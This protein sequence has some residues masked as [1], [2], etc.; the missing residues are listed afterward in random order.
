M[1]TSIQIW[2]YIERLESAKQKR[3]LQWQLQAREPIRSFA[4]IK[5]GDHL[6]RKNSVIN[7]L[8]PYEHH[9]LCIGNKFND[10]GVYKPE[11]I[12]YYNTPRNA[13]M[14]TSSTYSF[15]SGVSIGKIAKI[16]RMFLPHDDFIE[17]EDELQAAGLEVE[18]VVWP[19]ELRRYDVDEVVARAETRIAE[20]WYDAAENNCE[21]FVMWCLCNLNITLQMT[22]NQ[23][24]LYEALAAAKNMAIHGATQWVPYI[25][26]I[27]ATFA[28]VLEKIP[29]SYVDDII[30]ALKSVPAIG[31]F[32]WQTLHTNPEAL[33]VTI[34]FIIELI[35]AVYDIRIAYKKWNREDPITTRNEFIKEVIDTIVTAP[36]RFAGSAIGIMC[37]PVV[38]PIPYLIGIFAW[39]LIG[40]FFGDFTAKILTQF[41]FTQS[42]AD[43]TEWIISKFCE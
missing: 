4:D 24:M 8:L 43:L 38:I 22:P 17:N 42:A 15:G 9:F 10:K 29:G 33:G 11:I 28:S 5:V 37:G 30:L 20:N 36:F 21:S 23:R 27:I 34:S 18:R 31:E 40:V 19:E 41:G 6:I 39:P 14:Q 2:E 16:Q 7:G 3:L 12:H 1:S 35:M 26:D 32:L 13:S 25:D